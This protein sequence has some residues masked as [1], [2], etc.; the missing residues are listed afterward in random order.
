MDADET[1][2]RAWALWADLSGA[3]QTETGGWSARR[4]ED[5]TATEKIARVTNSDGK[6]GLLREACRDYF[7]DR[8]ATLLDVLEPSGELEELLQR[9]R[10]VL[11]FFAQRE[12]AARI[13]SI[14]EWATGARLH[15]GFP[16]E[17]FDELTTGTAGEAFL[18]T[19]HGEAEATA[20]SMTVHRLTDEPPGQGPRQ[21]ARSMWICTDLDELV[22]HAGQLPEG[23]LLVLVR[24]P[25]RF[26]SYFLFVVRDGGRIVAFSD[27]EPWAHPMQHRMTRRPDRRLERRAQQAGG[28]PYQ[29]VAPEMYEGDEAAKA[30]S[31]ELVEAGPREFVSLASLPPSQALW[32]VMAYD[33]IR[34]RYRTLGPT[35]RS[36]ARAAL[37]PALRSAE[38][39]LVARETDLILPVPSMAELVAAA[40]RPG[41]LE[42]SWLVHE[43]IG[44]ND[45]LVA[46]YLAAHP[47]TDSA[48][49]VGF[50][51]R[52]LHPGLRPE[53]RL[54]ADASW[55]ARRG[56][57][58]KVQGWARRRFEDER[59]E[60]VAW[61]EPRV[62]AAREHMLGLM[63]EHPNGLLAGYI[64]QFADQGRRF[65]LWTREPVRGR[66]RRG[67]AAWFIGAGTRPRGTFH[68]F[69]DEEGRPIWEPRCAL[70]GAKEGSLVETVYFAPQMPDDLA[71]LLNVPREELPEPLRSR[72]QESEPYM[73]NGILDRLDP[74]DA[75]LTDPWKDANRH[76]GFQL[77][78]IAALSKRAVRQLGLT[79]LEK[80]ST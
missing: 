59:R 75:A 52:E 42:P 37:P 4:W 41:D 79:P 9:G 8:Q 70:T 13:G 21:A 72:W 32:V 14:R 48:E 26:N 63:A 53:S 38:T 71:L 51:V 46:E 12:V 11:E 34:E 30:T 76:A 62:F 33:A 78:I 18:W 43:R 49:L 45:G 60:V 73:G 67:R 15:Y 66:G 68:L 24:A 77:R 55:L 56:L 80:R 39:A 6:L 28:L 74:L 47:E 16:G 69:V 29:Y 22:A 36:Y 31:Q 10:C 58:L 54:R 64:P 27:E 5:A 25:E 19:L 17:G 20:N 2:L 57:A 65:P 35:E 7:H 1:L 50:A 44:L 23:I 61:L 40:E 3:H